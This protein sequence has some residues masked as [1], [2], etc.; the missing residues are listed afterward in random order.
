M[1]QVTVLSPVVPTG[2][3]TLRVWDVA[4]RGLGASSRIGLQ[5]V[6]DRPRGTDLLMLAAT[7][8]RPPVVR[9]GASAGSG[10]G[11][12]DG[13]L[14][15]NRWL[16]LL[17]AWR[18]SKRAGAHTSPRPRLGRFVPQMDRNA[19]KQVRSSVRPRSR[20]AGEVR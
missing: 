13:A 9:G 12:I 6:P 7:I 1:L 5:H 11:R 15:T 14:N 17:R 8:M 20:L 4:R 3:G 16:T 2:M 10:S 18:A 19:V